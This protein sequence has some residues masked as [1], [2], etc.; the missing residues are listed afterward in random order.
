MGLKAFI[1]GKFLPFHKGHEAMIRFALTKCRHLSV[2]VCASDQETIRAAQ[3]CQWIR[4]TFKDVEH[5]ALIPFEYKE[6]EL[7]NSSVSSHEVSTKWANAFKDIVSDTQA[8]ITSEP[9]GDYVAQAL[10]I[11]HI[12]FDP[13]RQEVSISASMICKKPFK[14]WHMLPE[15]VKIDLAFTVVIL[16]TES[17]GKTTLTQNLSQHFQ[18]TPVYEVGREL[19]ESSSHFCFDELAPVATAHA[20]AM[21]KG[22]AGGSPLVVVD[23]DVHITASYARFCFKRNLDISPDIQAANQA[24]LYLYLEKDVIFVQDGT[25]MSESQRDLLDAS[26]RQVLQDNQISYSVINGSWENRFQQAC[27]KIHNAFSERPMSRQF[28]IKN[29]PSLSL[30]KRE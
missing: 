19:I 26:H 29:V 5:L 22:K 30:S 17:T 23:T 28:R 4:Q 8:V 12:P 6:S 25:R 24:D 15:A 2:I 1:F 11:Q 3:R 9:Y 10:S 27:F 16:G 21:L 20:Q 14:Y 7:P 18:A 13:H